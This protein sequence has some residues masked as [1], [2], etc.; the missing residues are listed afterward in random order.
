MRPYDIVGPV[1]ESSDVF[2]RDLLM[3]ELKRGDHLAI[4]SAGAYGAVMASSYNMRPLAESLF[5]DER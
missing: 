2:E 1:C 5:S 3:P 4:R